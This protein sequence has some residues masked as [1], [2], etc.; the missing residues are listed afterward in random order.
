ME[1]GEVL[2]LAEIVQTVCTNVIFWFKDADASTFED[3]LN[4]TGAEWS[5]LLF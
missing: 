1:V 2:V 5:H 3:W 4:E